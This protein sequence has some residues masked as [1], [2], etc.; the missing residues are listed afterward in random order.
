MRKGRIKDITGDS[1]IP[2]KSEVA[3]QLGNMA[4]SLFPSLRFNEIVRP[5]LDLPELLGPGPAPWVR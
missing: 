1:P 4:L 2:Q 5:R 3:N